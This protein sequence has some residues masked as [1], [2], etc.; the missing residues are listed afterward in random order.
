MHQYRHGR[1]F[2]PSQQRDAGGTELG[3]D[4]GKTFASRPGDVVRRPPT[5]GHWAEAR[6]AQGYH[7]RWEHETGNDQLKTHLRGPVRV[8]RSRSPDMVRQEIYGYP[9]AHYAI[10]A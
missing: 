4:T 8:L 3:F 7:D 2:I 1:S 5:V 10:S 6:G 9:L